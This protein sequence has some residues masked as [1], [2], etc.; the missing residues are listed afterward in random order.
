MAY[1]P[2]SSPPPHDDLEQA[3]AADLP[4]FEIGQVVRHRRYGYRGVIVD[5]D[6]TCHADDDW[7]L[8]NATQPDRNQPWYHVLVDG[9][10]HTTYV[11]EENLV[12][13]SVGRAVSHPLLALFFEGCEGGRYRR[14]DRPWPG[15]DADAA[16]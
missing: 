14:N 6:I 8:A 9:A 12:A 3:F 1:P 7:Y 2:E 13:G 5:F 15:S 4:A 11:A 10:M 16:S